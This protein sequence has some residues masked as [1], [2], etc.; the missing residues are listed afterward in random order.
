MKGGGSVALGKKKLIKN[1]NYQ[2]AAGL[3]PLHRK[4]DNLFDLL[5]C[6]CEHTHVI[7]Y[8]TYIYIHTYNMCVCVYV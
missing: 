6:V 5:V 2:A 3:Y 7:I 4:G 1:K 8:V